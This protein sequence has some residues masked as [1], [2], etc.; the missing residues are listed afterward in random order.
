M[1]THKNP[2]PSGPL[3]LACASICVLS[4]I[5][6]DKK[7]MEKNKIYIIPTTQTT[8]NQVKLSEI[9]LL[10]AAREKLVP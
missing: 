5:M 7:T 2:A 4:F 9:P 3:A 1:N 10:D 6:A 8:T